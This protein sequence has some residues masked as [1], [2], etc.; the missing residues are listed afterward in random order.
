MENQFKVEFKS[1]VFYKPK[2]YV[3]STREQYGQKSFFRILP[4][5]LPRVMSVGRLDIESEGLLILTNSPELSNF[6]ERPENKIERKY[7]VNV[8]GKIYT[9]SLESL[10]NGISKGY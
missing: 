6:L 4:K 9:N 7:I 10:K 3:C 1:L 5:E 2:G 8:S